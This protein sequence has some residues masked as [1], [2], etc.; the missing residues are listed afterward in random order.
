M[1]V[2][3][4]ERYNEVLYLAD[5]VW[6]MKRL[7]CMRYHFRFILPSVILKNRVFLNIKNWCRLPTTLY[8]STTYTSDCAATGYNV[9]VYQ[10]TDCQTVLI[11]LVKCYWS[12]WPIGSSVRQPISVDYQCLTKPRSAWTQSLIFWCIWWKHTCW[13]DGA[14]RPTCRPHLSHILC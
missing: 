4:L 14:C 3:S 11:N 7:H 9:A 6:V 12:K 8:S 2:V 10:G 13:I 1:D 5:A